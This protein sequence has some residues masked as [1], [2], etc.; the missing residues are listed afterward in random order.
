MEDSCSTLEPSV[1]SDDTHGR[2]IWKMPIKKTDGDGVDK[3]PIGVVQSDCDHM[4]DGG[5]GEKTKQQFVIPRRKDASSSE[6]LQ[7]VDL[8]TRDGKEIQSIVQESMRKS[9]SQATF[10]IQE[11]HIVKNQ[12]QLKQYHAKRHEMKEEGRTMA[13]LG[14]RYGFISTESFSKVKALCENGLST[15]SQTKQI[16]LGDPSYGVYLCKHAD[17]VSPVPP[18]VGRN[19]YL[20]VFKYTKVCCSI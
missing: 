2:S 17:V 15:E 8:C 7:R 1:S 20:V 10:V 9:E 18:Q 16:V 14:E 5:D 13:E 4:H 19:Y 11:M 12:S 6:L 3:G